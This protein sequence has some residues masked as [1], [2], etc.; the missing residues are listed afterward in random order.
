MRL[1]NFAILCAS[2]A[3]IAMPAFAQNAAQTNGSAAS[4]QSHGA[5][6]GMAPQQ[7]LTKD[8]QKAGFTNIQVEPEAFMVHATNSEGQHVLM[9]ITPDSVESVTAMKTGGNGS[10]GGSNSASNGSSTNG[11][12]GTTKE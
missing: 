7:A 1:H 11:H 2:G 6:P 10:S 4:S 5:Q 9:R 3:F 12:T 8:L